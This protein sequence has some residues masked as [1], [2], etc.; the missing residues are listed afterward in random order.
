MEPP[1]PVTLKDFEEMLRAIKPD[2]NVKAALNLMRATKAFYQL[3]EFMQSI[4]DDEMLELQRLKVPAPCNYQ[5]DDW[6]KKNVTKLRERQKE[7]Q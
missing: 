7:G 2:A 5:F 6:I 3:I 1:K 4:P